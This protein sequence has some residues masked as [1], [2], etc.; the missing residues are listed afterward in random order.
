MALVGLGKWSVRKP[1]PLGKVAVNPHSCPARGP[2][3]QSS[4]ERRSP[5]WAGT[6]AVS[7]TEMGPL[8]GGEGEG[9]EGWV[10]GMGWVGRWD[11]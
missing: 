1:A 9:R 5:G 11:G 4:T 8:G 2:S 10:G 7:T 6:P 3:W